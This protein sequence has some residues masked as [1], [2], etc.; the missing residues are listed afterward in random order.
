MQ[1][2]TA[3]ENKAFSSTLPGYQIA[4]DSTA[5]GLLKT[6]PRLYYYTMIEGWRPREQNVHLTFGIA[7]HS[8]L[9]HFDQRQADGLG[10]EENLRLAT[11]EALTVSWGW[12]FDE[13]NKTRPNFVRTIIWYLLSFGESDNLRTVVLANG[14][15]AVELSFRMEIDL[16]APDGQTY[17]LCGHL[18]RLATFGNELYIVDRKTT[19]STIGL[20]FFSKFTPDNQMSLYS[21]AGKVVYNQPVQGVL[22]DGAQIAVNFSRFERG[23]VNRT[24]DHLDEWLADTKSFLRQAEGYAEA[25]HWPMN[26][27]SCHMY[28]GCSF[29]RICSKSPAVRQAF[30]QNEFHKQVWDPLSTREV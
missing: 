18:D 22:V 7:L 21:L 11:R 27:K 20:D 29:R 26:D 14:K 6:C 2:P 19:K 30:I 5:L 10:F 1:L 8:V 9:E 16:I 13:P 24:A 23:F 28:G 25:K 4:W 15:A 12:N 3:A 17:L